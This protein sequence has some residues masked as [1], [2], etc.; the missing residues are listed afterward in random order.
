MTKSYA[1]KHS[2]SIESEKALTE[3]Y[4]AVGWV[5]FGF[6]MA[7]IIIAV[8]FLRDIGVV[9][10][11]EE[12]II[13]NPTNVNENIELNG[14]NHEA[15]GQNGSVI[16]NGNGV[17]PEFQKRVRS[18]EKVKNS[19]PPSPD[20]ESGNLENGIESNETSI[21]LKRL[22]SQVPQAAHLRSYSEDEV[23]RAV[24]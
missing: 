23:Q 15:Q 18:E 9:G 2:I 17:R 7:S 24:G 4:H 16:M 22:R 11:A 20:N 6:S 8:V 14:F 5:C 21:A 10:G 12:K 1:S 13:S 19:R 3:G